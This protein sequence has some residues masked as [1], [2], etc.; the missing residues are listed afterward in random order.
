[1]LSSPFEY[2]YCPLIC[3]PKQDFSEVVSIYRKF[4]VLAIKSHGLPRGDF[5]IEEIKN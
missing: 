2:S 5:T 4:I 3:P 1:M